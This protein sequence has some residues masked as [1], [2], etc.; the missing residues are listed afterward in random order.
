MSEHARTSDDSLEGDAV[1][2]VGFVLAAIAVAGMLVPLRQ[3]VDGAVVPIA[4]A[5]GVVAVATFLGRRY[6]FVDRSVGAPFTAGSLLALVLLAGY[7]LNQGITGSVSLPIGSVTIASV[8]VAFLAAGCGVGIAIADYA[9]I[10]NSGLKRRTALTFQLTIVGVLGLVAAQIAVLP[11]AIPVFLLVDEPGTLLISVLGY[12]SFGLGIVVVTAGFLYVKN[13]DRS[14]IDLR[15]P[16]LRDLA[17]GVGGIVALFGVAIAVSIVMTVVGVDA[18]EHS[19]IQEGQ[20]NPELLLYSIPFALLIIGPF[21]ELLY[22]NVIQKSMYGVFSRGGAIV[23]ASV[24]FA[25][26]HLLAYA[27]AGFGAIL[28]SLGLVFVLSL[29]LG[30]IYE[31]TENL[32]IPAAVHGVYNALIFGIN[33]ATV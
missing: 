23:V 17:W 18:A 3:G 11:L 5:L 2:A 32:L 13:L 24:V 10:S 19:S 9:G 28:S 15:M 1:V 16:T 12:L 7:A 25:A 22:R 20:E 33:F 4:V 8:F 29:L 30:L 6:G 27:T 26:V 31:R 21:E 14:F